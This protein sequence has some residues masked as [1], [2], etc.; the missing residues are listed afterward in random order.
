MNSTTQNVDLRLSGCFPAAAKRLAAFILFTRRQILARQ[1][2][3]DRTW[4]KTPSMGWMFVPL[5]PY[6][7]GGAEAILEPLS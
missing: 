4:K 3:F 6:H 1:N 2:I 5:M 7:G